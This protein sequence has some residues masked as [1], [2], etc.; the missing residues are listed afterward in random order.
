MKHLKSLDDTITEIEEELK[1][2]PN[3]FLASTLE[4]L[5]IY[6]DYDIEKIVEKIDDQILDERSMVKG[7]FRGFG[8]S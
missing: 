3:K 4:R 6:K 1:R 7:G 8:V 5:K 2:N